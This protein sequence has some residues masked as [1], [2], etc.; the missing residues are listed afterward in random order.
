MD[1]LERSQDEQ[2]QRFED[3]LRTAV[4]RS[5]TTVDFR[6][7]RH[8]AEHIECSSHI[9]FTSRQGCGDAYVAIAPRHEEGR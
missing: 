9:T 7:K 3:M 8:R 2:R 6:P 1:M 5:G 4:E